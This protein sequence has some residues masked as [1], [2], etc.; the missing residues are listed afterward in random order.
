MVEVRN[1]STVLF[2]KDLWHNNVLCDSHPRLFS[3]AVD[4]DVSVQNLLTSPTLSHNFQLTI[5]VQARGELHDLQSSMAPIE[6]TDTPDTWSCVWGSGG[7]A[8]RKYYEHCFREVVVD[9][10]FKW[11]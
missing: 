5:Y 1:G 7:F 2:W 6:L 4:E 11:S 9:D 3:F 10:S 8:S